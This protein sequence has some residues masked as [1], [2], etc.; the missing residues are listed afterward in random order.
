[1]GNARAFCAILLIGSVFLP[2]IIT[3]KA[4]AQRYP[5]GARAA[6][7]LDCDHPLNRPGVPETPPCERKRVVGRG[8]SPPP[9]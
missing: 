1:M 3:L 8:P 4:G 7:G 9:A 5:E 2:G 6:S